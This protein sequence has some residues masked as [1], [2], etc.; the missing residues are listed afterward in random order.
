MFVRSLAGDRGMIFP[1]DPPQDVAFW[2]KNTLIPLDMVFIRGDGTIVRITDCQAARRDAVAGR[3]AD[4]RGAG[5]SRRP[6]G[7][8]RHQG[9]RR[10]WSGRTNPALRRRGVTRHRPRAMG[11]WSRTFTWWNGATWGTALWTRPLRR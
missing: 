5:N 2:M 3:R 6:R 7:R 1:Y 10:A 4:R 9:R 11:F 8:A